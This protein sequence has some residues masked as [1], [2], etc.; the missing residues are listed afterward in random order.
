MGEEKKNL[1]LFTGPVYTT[2]KIQLLLDFWIYQM[3][4]LFL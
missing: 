2:I 3:I 1:L 4:Q